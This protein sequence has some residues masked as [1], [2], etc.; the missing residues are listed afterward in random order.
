MDIK[1][2]PM[3]GQEITKKAVKRKIFLLDTKIEDLGLSW[4]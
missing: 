4:W 2:V 3:E 1:E